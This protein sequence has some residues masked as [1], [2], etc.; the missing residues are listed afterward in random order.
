VQFEDIEPPD[1]TLPHVRRRAA[2][3]AN[4]VFHLQES[5]TSGG[6][7]PYCLLWPPSGR[8]SSVEARL[9]VLESTMA[10]FS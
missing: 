8:R 6:G 5:S 2:L 10:W 7:V 1:L 9:R 3:L 4:A